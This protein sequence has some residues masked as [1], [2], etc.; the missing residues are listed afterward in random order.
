MLSTCINWRKVSQIFRKKKK[1][2]HPS[3]PKKASL[4]FKVLLGVI[5]FLVALL[6]LLLSFLWRQLQFEDKVEAFLD[7]YASLVEI[8]AAQETSWYQEGQ[9]NFIASSFA[10]S[11]REGFYFVDR[12][13]Q[14]LKW[15]SWKDFFSFSTYE[16]LESARSLLLDPKDV[17]QTSSNPRLH[18]QYEEER[19]EEEVESDPELLNETEV[20]QA[21]LWANH[22]PKRTSLWQEKAETLYAHPVKNL[23]PWKDYLY[24]ISTNQGQGIYRLSR[25]THQ[26]EEIF[27]RPSDS[28]LYFAPYFY[29]RNLSQGNRL[30]R[31]DPEKG[32][33]LALTTEGVRAFT[34]GEKNI[35]YTSYPSNLRYDNT[36]KQ[37]LEKFQHALYAIRLNGGGKERLLEEEVVN[38]HVFGT[39]LYFIRKESNA[40]LWVMD[41]ETKA[42]QQVYAATDIQNFQAFE[43][44]F[45]LSFTS[46]KRLTL[47]PYTKKN[48][49]LHLA[50][51]KEVYRLI[52]KKD[53]L[54]T[55]A[56]LHMTGL[57]FAQD[58]KGLDV[59]YLPCTRKSWCELAV[60]R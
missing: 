17:N 7:E 18:K 21:K 26:I 46:I 54:R 35:Y 33:I 2:V 56:L 36:G 52:P 1:G 50:S 8:E 60:L 41:L 9:A 28:L 29:F 14:F 48:S 39:Q 15:I 37:S 10:V 31:M 45:Y 44:E 32:E 11:T 22:L 4:F 40:S 25:S 5:V 24:F 57:Y 27:Q 53:L 16:E 12:N 30:Y 49:V 38:L 43:D 59:V 58:N 3:K 6:G 47:E 42:L 55:S 20:K 19:Q 13:T 51:L 34:I 23:Y